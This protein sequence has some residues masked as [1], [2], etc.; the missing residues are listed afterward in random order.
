VRGFDRRWLAIA[1]MAICV[2]IYGSNFAITRAG[3]LA[4]F[5]QWD[6]V[7]LRFGVAGVILLPVFLAAGGFRTC[8]GIG[9]RNGLILSVLSGAPMSVLMILGLALAP[10]SHGATIT[11]GTVTTVSAIGAFLLFGAAL[12]GRALAGLALLF[13]GLGLIA[14][15]GAP[16][17]L[18]ASTLWGDL[19]FLGAGLLWGL[20]P[21]LLQRWQV[22]GLKAT[23]VLSVL[24][25]IAVAP[26]YLAFFW[27]HAMQL[28]WQGVLLHGIN[29]GV[30]NGVVGLWIW[31]WAVGVIGAAAA[32]RFP[33]LI[34][35]V[36]T[37]FAIPLLGEWPVALQ[38]AGVTAVVCGLVLMAWRRPAPAT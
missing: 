23:A 24:S 38:W 13:V 2:L 7:A 33:P 1:G 6:M 29:Q 11:P 5:T 19:C 17:D 8:G 12:T 20:Y 25:M 4:G 31:G 9:W 15:A 35:V 37:L 18:G 22:D 28:P 26:L 36:G 32:G 34:P 14:W 3:L 21:L 16:G 27:S 10:A 30:F